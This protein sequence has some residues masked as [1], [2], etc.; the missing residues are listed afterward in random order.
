MIFLL[1][2]G[3]KKKRKMMK[4]VATMSLPA[5]EHRPLERRTLAPKYKPNKTKVRRGWLIWS[6]ITVI[7]KMIPCFMCL[8]Y[9]LKALQFPRCTF[10]NSNFLISNA[11]QQTVLLFHSA[12]LLAIRRCMNKYVYGRLCRAQ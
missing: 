4:I 3:R 1:I 5:V 10:S 2:N 9:I 6:L 7:L 12:L 11:R 8:G